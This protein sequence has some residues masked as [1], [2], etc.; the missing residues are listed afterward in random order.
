MNNKAAPTQAERRAKYKGRTGLPLC[1]A[2]SLAPFAPD[3][4]EVHQIV[5]EYDIEELIQTL[6]QQ[7]KEREQ[8]QHERAVLLEQINWFEKVQS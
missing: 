7:L 8:R 3:A 5:A 1:I 2:R 4:S 6:R